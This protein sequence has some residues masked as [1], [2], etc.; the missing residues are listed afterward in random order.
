M[1]RRRAPSNRFIASQSGSTP[2]GRGGGVVA[3]LAAGGGGIDANRAP[4]SRRVALHDVG[5]L[6]T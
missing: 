2:G 6:V 5:K 1:H 4:R 3:T